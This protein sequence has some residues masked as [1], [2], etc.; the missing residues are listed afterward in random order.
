MN[1]WVDSLYQ[2]KINKTLRM[3]GQFDYAKRVNKKPL[4]TQIQTNSHV[5]HAVKIIQLHHTRKHAL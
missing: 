1:G 2:I 5:N 3:S 4:A